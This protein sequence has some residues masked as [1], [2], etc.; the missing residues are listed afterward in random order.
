MTGSTATGGAASTGG[1]G[2]GVESGE[3]G[4]NGRASKSTT[5]SVS[6]AGAGVEAIGASSGSGWPSGALRGSFDSAGE[7]VAQGGV[8]GPS[9]SVLAA[10]ASPS[11]TLVAPPAAFS[12]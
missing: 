6:A 5:S 9:S 4:V 8:R 3:V 1:V 2:G 10:L 7:A 11:L 12:P